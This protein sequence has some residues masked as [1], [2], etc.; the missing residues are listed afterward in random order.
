MLTE[1]TGNDG[2]YSAW[3]S[4]NPSG[5]V[6]NTRSRKDDPAYMVLHRSSCRTISSL[7]GLAASGGFTERAYKKICSDTV[8]ELRRWVRSHGRS[9]GSFSNSCG[10]CRPG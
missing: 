9:D 5:F 3:L 4:A 2:D 1:F 10:L 7:K 6:L 8:E